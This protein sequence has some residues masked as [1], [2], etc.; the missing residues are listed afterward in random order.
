MTTDIKGSVVIKFKDNL[1]WF[2]TPRIFVRYFALRIA[3][4]VVLFFMVDLLSTGDVS[5]DHALTFFYVG[6]SLLLF[7]V[8]LGP[9]LLA[10][11]HFRLSENQR[12]MIWLI[13]DKGVLFEDATGKNG[14]ILWRHI[15]AFD[16]RK[17]GIL[18]LCRG[19]PSKWIP[20]RTFTRS[21]QFSLSH[22]VKSNMVKISF[23]DELCLT[24]SQ[25]FKST[26]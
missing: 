16:I 21:D 6:L 26:S 3:F 7:F 22:L 19:G 17:N 12:K 18:I 24:I 2:L 25:F 20:S 1:D 23:V 4:L 8:V 5:L 13:S 10:W 11:A 15:R 14:M 9:I